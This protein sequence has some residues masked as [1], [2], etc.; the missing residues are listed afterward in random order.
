M[1]KAISIEDIKSKIERNNA[2][3]A[4]IRERE[5]D[6]PY[7]DDFL[8]SGADVY[9]DENHLL[10]AQMELIKNGCQRWFFA[11]ATLDGQVCDHR[12]VN[13]KYGYKLVV[14]MPDGSSVWT[15]AQTAK[16]LAKKGLKQVEV[17]KVAWCKS[18][19]S[20]YSMH[21]HIE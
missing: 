11:Y 7:G 17:R 4:K 9:V 6:E 20:A 8:R 3:I 21:P 18:V 5:A 12:W 1:A 13:T 14:D 2:F 16:G 19:V 10:E 15:T